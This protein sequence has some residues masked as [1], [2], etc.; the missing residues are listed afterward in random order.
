MKKGIIAP[1][2]A[3]ILAAGAAGLALTPSGAAAQEGT[4]FLLVPQ[5]GG[6]APGSA[7]SGQE[8]VLILTPRTAG[9]QGQGGQGIGQ[10]GQGFGQGASLDLERFGQELYARGYW[11]GRLEEQLRQAQEGQQVSPAR[12]GGGERP[13]MVDLPP[14][15]REP[16]VTT[17]DRPGQFGIFLTPPPEGPDRQQI[18]QTLREARRALQQ[19]E[20]QR[21]E[22]ALS[23]LDAMLGGGEQRQRLQQALEDAER[24]LQ[25]DDRQAAEEALRQARQAVQGQEQA[26]LTPRSE[27]QGQQDV[28][29][30]QEQQQQQPTAAR[31][32]PEQSGQGQQEQGEGGQQGR[33]Q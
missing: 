30:Q 5:G 2:L 15:Y 31:A 23:R 33:Q 29:Q 19:G 6:V 14:R 27:Q 11:Q 18:Q 20:A 21:A 7:Q 28:R 26:E 12:G 16:G 22:Q 1:A 8:Y 13:G 4:S 9:Q 3:S 17:F 32:R 24:A 25:R 10:P